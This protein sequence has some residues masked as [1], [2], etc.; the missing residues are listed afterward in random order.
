M[1]TP[2]SA[3]YRPGVTPNLPAGRLLLL[4]VAASYLLSAA[5]LAAARGRGAAIAT[6][7]VLGWVATG[8]IGLG[9]AWVL[10]PGRPLVWAGLLVVLGPW[11]G[12]SLYYDVRLRIWAM[13][14]IDAAGLAA[15][16]WGLW[17]ARAA[18]RA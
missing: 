6:W 1:A 16:A 14:A 11:M 8:L 10:Q 18:L 7:F 13:V 3:A 2:P 12:Y 4:I 5:L 15:I 17:L 9:L